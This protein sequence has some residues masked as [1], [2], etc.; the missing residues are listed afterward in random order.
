MDDRQWSKYEGD[1]F[2]RSY[3]EKKQRLK[4]QENWTNALMRQ[5]D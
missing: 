2:Q 4:W 1:G 5:V 3:E